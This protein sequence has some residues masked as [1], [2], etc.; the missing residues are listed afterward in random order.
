MIT[1]SN[2]AFFQEENQ[3]KAMQAMA[4]SSTQ[5]TNALLNAVANNGQRPTSTQGASTNIKSS[6]KLTTFQ[7]V[8]TNNKPTAVNSQSIATT[9]NAP[10][11]QRIQSVNLVNN[12]PIA[13]T[14]VS[15]N[16][17]PIT[18]LNHHQNPTSNYKVF[19]YSNK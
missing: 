8:N 14:I 15:S 6:V 17:S 11:I 18:L 2:D 3:L 16:S 12:Q 4:T 1:Y 7:I 13:K 9:S 10:V 5:E 19:G